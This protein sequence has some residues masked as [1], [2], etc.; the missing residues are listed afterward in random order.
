MIRMFVSD[1]NS[2]E[3]FDGSSGGSEASKR[4]ALAES[5]VHKESGALR[6][7]QRDVPRAPRR[8]YGYPQPDRVLPQLLPASSS[9]RISKMMAERARPVN[10]HSG[11]KR[12]WPF[13][14]A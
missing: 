7:E 13:E 14:K 12:C 10:E 6:L 11:E 4:F 9:K 1:E 5:A 8:Q 2:V 3:V